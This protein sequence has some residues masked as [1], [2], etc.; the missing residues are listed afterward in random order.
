MPVM[1]RTQ[2]GYYARVVEIDGSKFWVADLGDHFDEFVDRYAALRE[3]SGITEATRDGLLDPNKL[4]ALMQEVGTDPGRQKQLYR[5]STE[6]MDWMLDVCLVKWDLA[7][8]C[9]ATAK[10]ALPAA[11]KSELAQAILAASELNFGEATF[12][13]GLGAGDGGGR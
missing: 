13:G 10:R 2:D 11:V 7:A 1:L 5:E 3:Q 6:L 12:P 8:D 4:V 9:D